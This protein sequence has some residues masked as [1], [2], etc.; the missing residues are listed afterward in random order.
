MLNKISLT[1]RYEKGRVFPRVSCSSLF[2]PR[3]WLEMCHIWQR[4]NQSKSVRSLLLRSVS[5]STTVGV[6]LAITAWTAT[7]ATSASEAAATT[8]TEAATATSVGHEP[9]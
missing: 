3:D 7:A 1:L 6:A 8:S 9:P 5:T 4:S 2:E